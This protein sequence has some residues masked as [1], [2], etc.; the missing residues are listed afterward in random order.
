MK[1]STGLVIICIMLTMLI[2]GKLVARHYGPQA[3]DPLVLQSKLCQSYYAYLDHTGKQIAD[4]QKMCWRGE[5]WP[6]KT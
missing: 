6:P 5:D 2:V 4:L 1:H 3:D